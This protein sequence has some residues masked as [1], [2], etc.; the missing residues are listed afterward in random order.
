MPDIKRRNFLKIIGLTGTTAAMGCSAES[1]RKLIPYIIPPEEIVPGE[2]TWFATTCRECPAGCGMLAKNRDGR[3]IKVDGNPSHPVNRGAL[4]ARG[5]ASLHGLYNP[6]RFPGPCRRMGGKLTP[7][8]WPAGLDTMIARLKALRAQGRG[9]RIVFLSTLQ[10]GA[11]EELIGIWMEAL[12]GGERIIYEPFAYEL[13]R[14]ANRIVFG[15]DGIPTYRIDEAD[16]LISFGAGFLE[17][18]LSNVEYAR[19]YAT[20][21]APRGERKNFFVYVGPRRSMTGASSDLQ[22][23]V[24]PGTEWLVAAGLLKML[25]E[26]ARRGKLHLEPALMSAMENATRSL[27]IGV[28]GEAGVSRELLRAMAD[29]FLL[30]ERPLVLAGGLPHAGPSG[31]STAIAANLLCLLKP[32]SRGIVDRGAASA[33]GEVVPAA[34]MHKLSECLAGGEVDLLLLHEANPVFTLPSSWG[35]AANLQ[36][37]QTIVSFSACSDETT[38]LAHLV[39]PVH[40]PLESWGDHAPQAGVTGLM[41][42]VMGPLFD[43]CHL[44]DVLLK[45]G[46]AAG[47]GDKLPWLDF[48]SFLRDVWRRRWRRSASNPSFESFWREAVE[49]GGDWHEG[50]Q[51]ANVQATLPLVVYP[52]I[53]F[54]DGRTANR[55]WLQE[56]PDPV[57]QT[58]WGGWVEMH[59]QTAADFG[60]GKGDVIRLSSAHGALEAPVLPIGTVEPGVLALPIGQ[61]HT[62]FGRFADGKPANP[63]VLFS[64]GTDPFSG[65]IEIAPAVAIA[66]TDRRYAIANTDGSFFEEGRQI[67]QQLPFAAYRKAVT[68]GHR[69][70]VDMPL[71]EGFDTRKD[72]YPTHV[73]K[74]YR[75]CMV[76]DLD[77][78]IGCGA[79]VVACY[80]ENNVAV[81]GREQILLGREMSWLRVQRYF[82]DDGSTVH[83]LPMLC[84]QCDEAP[85][86]AVCPV[87][88]PHHSSEG[89]NNQVY[90]RCIGTRFCSQNDPYKVRRFNW[91]TFTRP[92]P[93]N[94]QLNPDVTVRQ[95][96][97]MEKCS[98]CVQRIV[99]A[100]IETRKLGRKVRD[101]DFTTACAQTCPTDALIFGN[102]LD[103]ESRVFRLSRDARAYQVFRS[104]NT[105]P[106]VIYLKKLTQELAR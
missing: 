80:A 87:F 29:R 8:S 65:G 94:W 76:V 10:T 25:C 74:E 51:A 37:V 106:A 3:I 44:G 28:A 69:P 81:V 19:K 23:I 85:C 38:S 48:Y 36:K 30:A 55:F 98:F 50:S 21:H 14:T 9:K 16:F 86:E 35:F 20:F 89:L 63:L 4:C 40:T 68:A 104:L 39:L 43:T 72:F 15:F 88:A 95:K 71:P 92:T 12:G 45:V 27:P 18:W 56:L 60:V 34:K 103:P 31:L 64:P 66:R 33:L 13:L 61:G 96:G 42:P 67:V 93:L 52:T 99:A 2:A 77:R 57:T 24:P 49:R 17:T 26:D 75:W 79:C 59:P 58:T 105:K 11:M 22:I 83:Y 1:A 82:S 78:C 91:F 41:Q 5:Q 46:Q 84:Q 62:R 47:G 6:D 100:K 73:H 7:A 97:V 54:F 70:D 102:L 53:Q 101:N 90:N 32:G